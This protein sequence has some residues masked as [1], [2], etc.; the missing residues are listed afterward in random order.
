MKNILQLFKKMHPK[1]YYGGEGVAVVEQLDAPACNAPGYT[2]VFLP[3][4]NNMPIQGIGLPRIKK[5]K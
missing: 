1:R 4:S 5:I 3:K 2:D